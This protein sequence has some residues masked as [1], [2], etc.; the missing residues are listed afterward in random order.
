MPTSVYWKKLIYRGTPNSP[1]DPDHIVLIIAFD[2]N[3]TEIHMAP[4]NVYYIRAGAHSVPAN[5]HV[6][7][8]LRSRRGLR[9]PMLRGLLR[10]NDNRRG[11]V[12]LLVLALNSSPALD[13]TLDFQPLPKVFLEDK[14]SQFPLFVPVI[15]STTPFRMDITTHLSGEEWFGDTPVCL[16]LSYHDI[17][18]REFSERQQIDL[19]SV[20]KFE[21]T[22]SRSNDIE[23]TFERMLLE[24][25][26]LREIAEASLK[27]K[28]EHEKN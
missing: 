6:L 23:K 26:R 1:I 7:E 27:P 4:D 20:S 24:I 21:I 5:H 17:A 22:T 8:A 19:R 28:D 2:G 9:E 16:L 10:V 3:S 12:E 15:D 11:V 13:V 14:D 25:R 18:H